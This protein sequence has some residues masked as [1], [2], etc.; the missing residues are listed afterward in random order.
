M[1]KID[2]IIT[3]VAA[4]LGSGILNVIFTHI[5]Y[6]RRLKRDQEKEY[7]DMIGKKV[8]EALLAVRDFELQC[9]TIEILD[10]EQALKNT[11]FDGFESQAACLAIMY[12]QNAFFDFQNQIIKIH[13]E[14][15]KY[16]GYEESAYL[17]Y[18]ERYC[19]N[20]LHFGGTYKIGMQKMGLV[21]SRDIREWQRRFDKLLVK[22]INKPKY[23]VYTNDSKRLEKARTKVKKDLWENA[24]LHKFKEMEAEKVKQEFDALIAAN[25]GGEILQHLD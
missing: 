19:G 21:F 9:E 24:L 22:K 6:G 5:V 17:R 11:N 13:Q 1:E 23:K 12:S 25:Y 18:I 14:Y 10:I 15:E 16:L 20:M 8:C 3:L 7:K 4:A 2:I